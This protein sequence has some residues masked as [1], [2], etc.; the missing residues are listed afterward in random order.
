MFLQLLWLVCISCFC[1]SGDKQNLPIDDYH[2]YYTPFKHAWF[3]KQPNVTSLLEKNKK[4]NP[5]I[6]EKNTFLKRLD[7]YRNTGSYE[8]LLLRPNER[9]TVED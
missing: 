1:I 7:H 4:S 6:D 8:D 3:Y 2:V 9:L 5:L